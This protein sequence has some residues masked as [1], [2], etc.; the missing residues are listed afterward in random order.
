MKMAANGLWGASAAAAIAGVQVMGGEGHA[1]MTAA[2]AVACLAVICYARRLPAWSVLACACLA[3]V[4]AV[5]A[6]YILAGAG[7]ALV[8]VS[9]VCAILG[10]LVGIIT[11]GGATGG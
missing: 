6:V 7:L 10:G 5:A 2:L 9:I 11:R 1:L 3:S 8:V 4:F